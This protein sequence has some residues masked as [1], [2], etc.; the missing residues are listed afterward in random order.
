M[1]QR[2][3]DLLG[4]Y[5]PGLGKELTGMCKTCPCL[6]VSDVPYCLCCNTSWECV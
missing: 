3:A 6:E 2:V 5:K 1:I 4:G